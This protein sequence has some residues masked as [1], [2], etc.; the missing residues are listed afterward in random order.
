MVGP[1]QY[2][3]TS[4]PPGSNGTNSSTVRESVLNKRRAING[5]DTRDAS[6]KLLYLFE[7]TIP[8]WSAV[9]VDSLGRP[10]LSSPTSRPPST[11]T[12]DQDERPRFSFFVGN[13]GR[14]TLSSPTRVPLID[15]DCR[16]SVRAAASRQSTE[17][18]TKL[19][20]KKGTHGH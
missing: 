18:P 20:T 12:I 9:F 10:S 14:P 1:Q 6:P 16:P 5:A 17:L 7:K 8:S 11:K 15:K 2:I 4:R 13:P 19:P 3:R